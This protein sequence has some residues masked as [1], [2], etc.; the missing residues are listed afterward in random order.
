[1]QAHVCAIGHLER[2]VELLNVINIGFTIH[3]ELPVQ[4][5]KNF[6]HLHMT[7]VLGEVAKYS[8]FNR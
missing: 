1:M 3:T 5:R 4:K 6:V 7:Y 8:S 2:P